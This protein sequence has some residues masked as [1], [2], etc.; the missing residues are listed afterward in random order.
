MHWKG[1]AGFLRIILALESQRGSVRSSALPSGVRWWM[2]NRRGRNTGWGQWFMFPSV[3]WQLF[4]GWQEGKIRTCK[5]SCSVNLSR[6]SFETSGKKTKEKEVVIRGLVIVSR[7][8]QRI[9]HARRLRRRLVARMSR[10]GGKCRARS[11]SSWVWRPCWGAE[12][13]VPARS[14]ED[15]SAVQVCLSARNS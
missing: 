7:M 10:P 4:F 15:S 3:I 9:T 14:A 8:Q 1:W 12:R 11:R 6:F 5:K 13:S 2:K